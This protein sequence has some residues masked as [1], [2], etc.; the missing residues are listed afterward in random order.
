[1]RSLLLSI[2]IFCWVLPLCSWGQ[3]TF[4][5]QGRIQTEDRIPVADASVNLSD[6]SFAITD[7]RG[8][9]VFTGVLAGTI[10]LVIRSLQIEPKQLALTVNQD[11]SLVIRV[12]EKIQNLEEV[13]VESE[14]DAFGVR[15]LRS[16]EAGG[17]YEGK[18]TEVINVERLVANKATNNARQ[19]FGKIP[20]LNIWESDGAGLQLDIGGRGLSPKRTSNFNTRQNGYDISADALG[21]PES[22]Y[23]PPLQAVQ[24]IE[25]VRGAGALQ[26][27]TQFG[28]LVN[29]KM[30]RG[31]TEKPVSFESH[32]SY[33]AYQ[34]INTFN[35]L[36][37]QVGK[38]NYY[39]YGQYKQGDGWRPNSQY[40][41]VGAYTAL[42]YQ[43]SER[44][45]LGFEYTHMYYLSQQAGGLTD[46][47]F[48]EDPAFSNRTRNWFRVNWNLANFSVEYQLAPQVKVY[49]RTFGLYAG[50]TSLGLLETPDVEDPM[51]NRDLIDG[52]FR[53][54]GNETRVVFNYPSGFDDY[55]NTLLVG[56]RLYRGV[57]NF[58]QSFGTDGADPDFTR[59]DTAFLDRRRSDFDFPN[60]N[61][62]LFVEKIIRLSP[63]FSL[64]PGVRYEHLQ[65]QSEGFFTSTIRTNSFGDFVEQVTYDTTSN[66]RSI[67][68]YGLGASKTI[69]EEYE[70]YANATANYRAINFTDVRIQT[71]TQLVD[72]LIQDES[73]YS[74][75]LGVRRLQYSPFF[76]EASAFYLL[77]NDRIGE[78]ID[79]GLRVR[80]NIGSAHIFGVELFAEVDLIKALNRPTEHKLSLFV[81]GSVNRGVYTSINPRALAGV[82]V[83]NRVEDLPDYNI[84]TGLSY[85]FRDLRA[86]LQ[87]TFVGQQFSDA[88]N[89]VTPFKGVFGVI[90][91]YQVVDL[92]ASYQFTNTV[93][94]EG[95]VNNLLDAFYFTRRAVAYPGPGIIPALRRTW[96]LTLV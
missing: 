5:L 18:K 21:Y 94:L 52:Q 59:V 30:K 44:L 35:S 11:T 50:R 82:R 8:A 6:G 22:Y 39:T 23:T 83:G 25:V 57:T 49:S 70:I 60:W 28:G 54:L 75:D 92:S 14:A 40:R 16:V 10:T 85:G 26:Y 32:N 19:A 27:G 17:L 78:V 84:K 91:A 56:S 86:S 31:S 38:L 64:I 12:V 81:N 45:Q 71:N 79:D 96:N 15:Q 76:I 88:A 68:L 65:T 87:G 63:T 95:S 93:A 80:T 42:Q 36:H 33:G 69:L 53:N 13:V 51:S 3:T 1:M 20:S 89:T 90:P 7:A 74:F 77:Y 4:K 24:Q 47:M 55:K 46:E 58:S 9:F 61:A 73:G 37:G 29:F 67:F 48:L 41:Q 43:A 72:T 2:L 62:A 66:Q 34:L